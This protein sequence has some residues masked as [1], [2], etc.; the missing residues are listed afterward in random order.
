A[1]NAKNV[2]YLDFPLWQSSSHQQTIINT[3]TSN[4]DIVALAHPKFGGGRT[5]KNMQELTGYH[6]TEV[7]N[8]YRVSDVYWDKALSVGHLSWI[9]GND[10]MHAVSDPEI[11]QIWNNI[12]SESPDSVL[13]NLKNG[14]NYS[15][16]S[17]IKEEENTLISC[18]LLPGDTVK[19]VFDKPAN[20]QFI[21][22]DGVEKQVST[23]TD[24]AKYAFTKDD[25][26]IRVVARNENSSIFLN[27]LLR[28]NGQKL[29]MASGL[30]AEQNLFLSWLWRIGAVGLLIGTL[31]VWRKVIKW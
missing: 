26:Y 10:D 20:I 27:P 21:G 29:T 1:I 25:T 28:Y 14:K 6:L 17:F 30:V 19:V 12:F 11:F 4:A 31:Y 15:T 9:I 2:S 13:V 18:T 16:Q 23:M 24:T 5:F 3:L 22:Q 7:L 8:H